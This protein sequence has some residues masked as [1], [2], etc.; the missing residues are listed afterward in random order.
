MLGKGASEHV[1][2]VRIGIVAVS[3]AAARRADVWK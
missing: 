1:P 3:M 2:S